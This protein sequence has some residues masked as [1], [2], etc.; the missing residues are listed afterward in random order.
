MKNFFFLGIAIIF[1]IIATSA[2]K[3]SEE[4]T[5][6]IPSII[7]ILGYFAAF[8]FLSFAIRTI[9]VGIAYAIWSGV[10]IVL[11]TIIG[12]VFFKQIPDLPAIIGLTLIMA[13]V[14]VINVF[15]KTTAH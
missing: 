4:F 11:I 5:R 13:G 6:L 15:S 14:I 12:A 1:E 8:Y 3:K 2:L 7:T 10:G 9:P